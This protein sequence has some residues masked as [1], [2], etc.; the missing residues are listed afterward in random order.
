[1]RIIVPVSGGKD[2]Q[3]TLILAMATGK[4]VIPVFHETDWD[5][6]LTYQH[7]DYMMDFFHTTLSV[8]HYFEAPTMPDLIRRNRR[9]PFGLGR[10]CTSKFKQVAQKRWLDTLEGDFEEWLGIRIDESGQRKTKYSSYSPVGLYDLEDLSKGKFPIRIR[11]RVR[12]RLPLAGHTREDVFRIIAGAGMRYNPLYD[13]GFDRVGCFPCLVSGRTAQKKAFETDFG[14]KQWAI[15]QQLEK[16][17]GQKY[18]FY[19]Q[20]RCAVCQI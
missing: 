19:D 14:Q 11:N 16:E 5:H 12:V 1:M 8:T 3:A 9:F 15:I 6:P 4:E 7:L 2:S 20:D 17:I 10:F 13:Q 18:E